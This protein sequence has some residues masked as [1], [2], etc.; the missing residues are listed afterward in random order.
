[1]F[2]G[3]AILPD[4]DNNVTAPATQARGN[5]V[6][7]FENVVAEDPVD[8]I[9]KRLW[10]D[11]NEDHAADHITFQLLDANNNP[12][13]VDGENTFILSAANNWTIK[14]TDIPAVLADLSTVEEID[15]PDGYE[16][17]YDEKTYTIGGKTTATHTILNSEI[18]GDWQLEIEK[19]WTGDARRP[20][21]IKFDIVANGK[22]YKTVSL[23]AAD[24]WHK[25]FYVPETDDAGLPID[26]QIYE[27]LIDNRELSSIDKSD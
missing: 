20:D 16:V 2:N 4:G 22:F 1:M 27:H 12:I 24:D 26:Y 10:S 14:F 15:V 21:S 7:D 13:A 8:I 19:I 23:T 11:G 25:T 5:L 9:V 17:S 18:E 3:E 6:V